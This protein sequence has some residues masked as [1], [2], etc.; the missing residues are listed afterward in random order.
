MLLLLVVSLWKFV[1]GVIVKHKLQCLT[2]V[3]HW[4]ERKLEMKIEY[5]LSG[6]YLKERKESERHWLGIHPIVTLTMKK[7]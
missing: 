1:L 7:V 2:K 3:L 6:E 4:K 5:P